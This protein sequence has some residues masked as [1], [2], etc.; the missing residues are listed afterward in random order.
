M[1]LFRYVFNCILA[2]TFDYSIVKWY[3]PTK[4]RKN[5][6]LVPIIGYFFT[7]M[8]NR[9]LHEIIVNMNKGK[10][11]LESSCFSQNI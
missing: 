5:Y 6:L 8:D 9:A 11:I 7:G 2:C 1:F 10:Q 4:K 3:I